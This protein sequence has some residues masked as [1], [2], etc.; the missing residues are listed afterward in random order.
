M[1]DHTMDR[2][3][4]VQAPDAT[5]RQPVPFRGGGF[6][7]R[8]KQWA[9]W[10][11]FA[12][13]IALWELSGQAGWI[14]PVYLP[15]PSDIVGALIRLVETGRIWDHLAASGI[16]LG[17]GWALGTLAGLIVGLAV[18]IWSL[19]RAVGLPVVS[20]LFPIPK[21]ALLPLLILWFGIGEASKV[22]TIAFGVFFPTVIATYAGVDGVPRNLIRM[23][24]SFNVPG[25][26]ILWKVVL[27]GTLPSILAGF[28]ITTSIALILLVAAEMIG[29]NSGIGAF[30]L[31]AGNLYQTDQLLAGV[32][33]LSIA[34]LVFSRGIGAIERRLL[35][36][37]SS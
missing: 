24:Q 31:S 18:G 36:W 27:P 13:I 34:G 21:I 8:P 20:A 37:R 7:A 10:L 17:A 12:A 4:G 5:R 1:V 25:Y 19:A 2:P 15:K 28:R 14:S 35:A 32:T 26:R 16:R 33:I 23:A 9:S 3:A 30:I 29:A 6:I 22:A 11:A